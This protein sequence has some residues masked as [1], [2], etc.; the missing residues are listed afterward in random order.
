MPD[1]ELVFHNMVEADLTDVLHIEKVSH[2]HPWSEGIFKDCLRV[3]YFCPTLK[4]GN[5]IV[6][7]G[8]MS[9]AAEEAHIFNICVSEQFRKQGYGVQVMVYLLDLAK[10][11]KAKSVF[12]EV[13]PSNNVAIQLYSKLGFIEVGIRKDYYP[14]KDGREDALI[15]AMD[16]F[17]E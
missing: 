14:S 12:L 1:S 2:A 5:D 6:A 8:V 16:I 9:I 13:R 11:K 3:G 17:Y 15:F 10:A 7:Y 4:Q